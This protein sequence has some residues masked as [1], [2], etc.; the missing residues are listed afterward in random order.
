MIYVNNER[1]IVRLPEIQKALDYIRANGKTAEDG[2]VELDGKNLYI[3]FSNYDSKDRKDCKYEAH[4]NYIDVQYVIE[5]EEAMAV[6]TAEGLSV[7]KEYDP[8]KDV[9]FFNDDKPGIEYVLK[10]GDYIVVFPDDVHMPKV[11]SGKVCHIKKAVV[12][13]KI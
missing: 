12:K 9:V 3:A 8:E 2:K 10:A 6:T 4:K 5:G 1:S 11:K 13:I 7:K